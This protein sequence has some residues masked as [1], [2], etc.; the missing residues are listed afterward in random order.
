M[1]AG[2]DNVM[3]RVEGDVAK[4]RQQGLFLQNTG[5]ESGRQ[6]VKYR[7]GEHCLAEFDVAKYEHGRRNQVKHSREGQ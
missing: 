2:G 3:H 7:I 4:V 6:K 5:G 1:R